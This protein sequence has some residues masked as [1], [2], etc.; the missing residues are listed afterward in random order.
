MEIPDASYGA[1]G[2]RTLQRRIASVL[3]EDGGAGGSGDGGGGSGSDGDSSDAASGVVGGPGDGGAAAATSQRDGG[4][5]AA[6]RRR[7]VRMRCATTRGSWCR[8]YLTQAPLRTKRAPRGS[9]ACPGNCSGVGN[10]NYDTGRCDCP[11]GAR[12]HVVAG[13]A[14]GAACGRTCPST[15]AGVHQCAGVALCGQ[16]A[17]AEKCAN[18]CKCDAVQCKCDTMRFCS[19]CAWLSPGKTGTAGGEGGA[20]APPH[21]LHAV[22]PVFPDAIISTC[23]AINHNHCKEHH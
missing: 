1:M 22:T 19:T 2:M 5:P 11:A 3:G 7:E 17:P 8:R 6:A 10:C 14:P 23:F 4:S 13:R 18:K 15:T 9:K 20:H 16:W 12:A 21:L